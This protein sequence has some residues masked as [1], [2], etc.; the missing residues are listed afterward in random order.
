MPDENNNN[1]PAAVREI[2][3]QVDPLTQ[4]LPE[5]KRA[6]VR[7]LVAQVTQYH[8]GPLPD[9]KTLASYDAIIQSGAERIM[10]L[11]EKRS[12]HAIKQEDRVVETQA[13]LALRGQIIG[14][15]LGVLGLGLAAYVTVLGHPA[16]AGV[17]CTTTILGIIT[18]FVLGRTPSGSEESD[19][20]SDDDEEEK[21][22]AASAEREQRRKKRRGR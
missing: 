1:L 5:D 17:I 15:V 4:G 9:P 20:D 19:D 11:V 6:Q 21:D 10:A 22:D 8:S 12:A 7:R 3:H 2:V 16:L 14:A 18:V 13:S